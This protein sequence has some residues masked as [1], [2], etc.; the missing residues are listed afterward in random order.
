MAQ[1]HGRLT[2]TA[3][4]EDPL[5]LTR[6]LRR[7]DGPDLLFR[8]LRHADAE[9]LAAFLEG[10]SP[11]SRRLSTFDGYDLASA[12]ESCD[13]IARYD[14]LRLVLEEV[15]SGRIVGLLEI[16]LVL[17]PSDIARYREAGIR[18]EATDCRFGPTLADDHQGRGTGTRVFPLVRDVAQR[19]GKKRI[20]LWGGVLADNP[21]AI[22]YY[23]KQGFQ[24]AGSF[25]DTD[26]TRALDMILDL[27]SATAPVTARDAGRPLDG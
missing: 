25:T 24:T 14:K 15:P 12:R 6:R 20:I 8:P 3:V 18:L 9:R 10:L 11:E 27:A 23:E 21:R 19:F 4:A 13:A 22:R 17:H 16:S 7:D 26:G 1:A 5:A 2:L